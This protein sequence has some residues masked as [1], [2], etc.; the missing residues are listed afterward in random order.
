[1]EEGRHSLS[2]EITCAQAQA[3][4]T[5]RAA[6]ILASTT[7]T[8]TTNG[9]PARDWRHVTTPEFK[10]LRIQLSAQLLPCR[11]DEI[12]ASCWQSTRLRREFTLHRKSLPNRS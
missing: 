8:T 9:M 12:V 4:W 2:F 10:A 3:G 11:M 5:F 6:K 7:I 1:M